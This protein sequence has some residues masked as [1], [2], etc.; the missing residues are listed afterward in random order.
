MLRPQRALAEERAAVG[1]ASRGPPRTNLGY[2]RIAGFEFR[3]S[4]G[5]EE[6]EK[7]AAGI[8]SHLLPPPPTHSAS[9]SLFESSSER[10]NCG[11]ATTAVPRIARRRRRREEGAD[12]RGR[13]RRGL[14]RSSVRPS[15]G[16]LCC[17]QSTFQAIWKLLR[18]VVPLR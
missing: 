10:G 3:S 8:N 15:V 12:G 18:H 7:A 9:P 2:D 13:A 4:G 16:P 11:G 6:E 5:G 1:R 17:A 14:S